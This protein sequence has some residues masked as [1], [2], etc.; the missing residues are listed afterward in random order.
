MRSHDLMDG[1][2]PMYMGAGEY[3]SADDVKMNMLESRYQGAIDL[4]VQST[5]Y[6]WVTDNECC[7]VAMHT[8]LY[9]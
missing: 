1:L 3:V 7:M 4:S 2:L 8:R 9:S 5:L 6:T